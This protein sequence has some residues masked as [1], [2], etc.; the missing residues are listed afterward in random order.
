MMAGA[1]KE[2]KEA[3]NIWASQYDTDPNRTRDLEGVAL[4]Q[5]LAG[6]R[7][8]SCLEIGCGT[9]KNTDWL[10]GQGNQVTSVDFSEEMLAQARRKFE[11]GRVRFVQAD[12]RER[13]NFVDRQFDLITFSLVLEHVSE[14]EPIFREAASALAA[15]GYVYIGEL[16]PFKQYL[17]SKAR[18]E[19]DGGVRTVECFT[20]HI[21]DFLGA[22]KSNGLAVD[23]LNEYFDEDDR[24]TAPRV[25]TL[26]LRNR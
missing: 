12:I 19:A 11:P 18:F 21:S 3:Y 26:G 7:F 25:L 8:D 22:A 6:V 4:R 16:H 13:W 10:I 15:G 9:G 1:M 2:T 24:G 5:E 20:H 14:L 17:G 23:S